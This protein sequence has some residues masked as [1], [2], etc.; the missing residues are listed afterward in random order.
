MRQS[1]QKPGSLA[2]KILRRGLQHGDA[3]QTRAQR[4]EAVRCNA[5]LFGAFTT[6]AGCHLHLYIILDDLECHRHLRGTKIVARVALLCETKW[7]FG[8]VRRER[9]RAREDG[10]PSGE[11]NKGPKRKKTTIPTYLVLFSETAPLLLRPH[12]PP[13]VFL[14]CGV[15]GFGADRF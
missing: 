6:V 10:L 8:A 4:R 5:E 1:P 14:F 3:A 12:L 9:K 13:K 15:T 7:Q 11:Q 2:N